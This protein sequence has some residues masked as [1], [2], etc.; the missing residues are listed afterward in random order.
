MNSMRSIFFNRKECFFTDFELL[1]PIPLMISFATSLVKSDSF[2]S[3]TPIPITIR[4]S[5]LSNAI[6]GADCPGF[7]SDDYVRKLF[8]Q[9]ENPTLALCQLY[10]QFYMFSIC[11]FC[12]LSL[13]QKLL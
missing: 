1:Q 8:T 4:L 7:S 10:M 9:K 12:H 5:A 11:H 2:L 13:R 3:L 6:L